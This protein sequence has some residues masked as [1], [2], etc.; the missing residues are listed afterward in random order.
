MEDVQSGAATKTDLNSAVIVLGAGA[1]GLWFSWRAARAGAQVLLLEKTPRT[2]TKI[3]A[4]G[5]TRCNVTTSL[6]HSQAASLFGQ[7]GSRFLKHAFE[8]LPPSA[9]REAFAELGVPTEEAPLEKVFPR[10]GRA[11]DVRDALEVA[12]RAAGVRIICNAPGLAIHRNGNDW[13]VETPLGTGCCQNLVLAVG[14]RSFPSTG[15][16]GEGYGWLNELDL[17]LTPTTPALVPLTSDESWVQDLKGIA[18]QNGEARLEDGEG[19]VVGR[20]RRPL[21]FTHLG[22][23]GPAAMDLSGQVAQGNRTGLR[24][25][26]DFFPQESRQETRTRL[27]E[28]AGRK[29]SPRISRCLQEP[30]PRRLL[31]AVARAAELSGPDPQAL[32]LDRSARHRLVETLHGLPIKLSG[33]R[34][35]EAAEVTRGGLALHQVDPFS[36]RVNR[37]RG[38]IVLG[39]LLDL[40]GPIGGLNF[41]VAFACAEVAALALPQ[42]G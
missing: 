4:S 19:K 35:F 8:V 26:L 27:I 6:D 10:S 3:L 15:T 29:G 22:L 20:R 33:T 32:D 16:T 40:D 42:P 37:L 30:L 7:R 9:V 1:A 39:E 24:L 31:N 14:G 12:A 13:L 11:R 5:G 36:M 41:Q 38:L 34:G 28:G 17:E 25:L 18:W 21:L 23:S 2:G